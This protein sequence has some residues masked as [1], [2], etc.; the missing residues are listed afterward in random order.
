MCVKVSILICTYNRAELLD[1]LLQVLVHQDFEGEHEIVI[2]D[3]NSTD[4]TKAV[5]E[6][7]MPLANP[8]CPIRYVF[9][10]A[11]QGISYARNVSVDAADGNVVAF[12]DDDAI[13][14]KNWLQRIIDNFA[15]ETVAAVGGKV[16][17]AWSEPP[18]DWI[19]APELSPAIGATHYGEVRRVMMG[20]MAPL[21]GNMAVRKNWAQA[22]GFDLRFGK[23]G[24]NMKSFEEIEFAD[25]LCRRGGKMIYDPQMVVYHCLPKERMTKDYVARRRYGDGQ[26]LSA[27]E[28]KRGGRLRQWAIGLALVMLNVLRDLPGLLISSI[29][30][31]RSRAFICFCR[32][33]RAQGYLNE[34]RTGLIWS[35]VREMPPDTGYD[36]SDS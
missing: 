33:K 10:A 14:E 22:L 25:R 35:T 16:I 6:K 18:S 27:F 4:G 9:A 21:A 32:L 3:N 26:S 7:W 23:V 1:K 20:K 5:A 11:K 36:L 31:N 13:P 29:L 12:I 2:V 8:K 34:M 15:D 24:R 30:G 19:V 17:P 28:R